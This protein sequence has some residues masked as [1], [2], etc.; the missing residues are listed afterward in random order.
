MNVTVGSDSGVVKDKKPVGIYGQIQSSLEKELLTMSYGWDS[1]ESE[2]LQGYKDG[3][4]KMWSINEGVGQTLG[5]IQLGATQAVRAI[6]TLADR[7]LLVGCENG[8]ISLQKV[9]EEGD[10]KQLEQMS[11]SKSLYQLKVDQN[12][13]N[14]IAIG[15]KNSEISVFD[16]EKKQQ[17]W[18][19][20]N[21]PNDMLG[22]A[23]LIWI[24]DIEL[25]GSDKIVTGTGH[26]E[27]RVYDCRK[28]R[29]P[30]AINIK[31]AKHP[32][33]S[34]KYSNQFENMIIIA[35]SVGNV[36]S[37]DIRNG[38]SIG[39]YKG[40]TGSVRCIDVHPTLP[41]L[42]TVGLDRHLRVFDIDSRKCVQTVYLKQKMSSV[43]FSAEEPPEP[44][45]EEETTNGYA[46]QFDDEEEEEEYNDDGGID[47]EENEQIWN[48]IEANAAVAVTKA[49]KKIANKKQQQQVEEE[50]DEEDD[51]DFDEDAEFDDDDE[52]DSDDFGEDDS[53]DDDD[54][55]DD[56]EESEEEEPV[57]SKK[58]PMVLLTPPN[59]PNSL[60]QIKT[61]S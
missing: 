18:R 7:R 38:K 31:L 47:D 20:K 61:I 33:L 41:L 29:S 50:D 43:L 17:V 14:R 9:T 26:A 11:F 21:A 42:A 54:S 1:N 53:G 30:P 22:I 10:A 3:T 59:K 32:I 23:P 13:A 52:G 48:Q 36:N 40:N 58:R 60:K 27:M 24:T 56:D 45:E 2:L 55:E 16:I 51:E 15:G 44:E 5:E 28:N 35:D 34:I 6:R 46:Q 39:S 12:D 37:Y 57:K 25:V 19:A 4:V 49:N 8:S